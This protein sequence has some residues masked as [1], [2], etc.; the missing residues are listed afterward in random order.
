[1]FFCRAGCASWNC[2][3]CDADHS[4]A[5][6]RLLITP[7]V[8]VFCCAKTCA[9]ALQEVALQE[10]ETDMTKAISPLPAG[11]GCLSLMLLCRCQNSG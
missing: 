1:V 6:V 9:V 4:R 7:Q 8:V 10:K 2:A 11:A 5:K 3:E